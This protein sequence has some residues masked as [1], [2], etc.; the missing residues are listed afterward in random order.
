MALKESSLLV[1]RC[2][3]G[4][5]L[6]TRLQPSMLDPGPCSPTRTSL[7]YRAWPSLSSTKICLSQIS[8]HNSQL[9]TSKPPGL[10]P[11]VPSHLIM[12][13]CTSLWYRAWPSLSSTQM[14]QRRLPPCAESLHVNSGQM[15][16]CTLITVLHSKQ[17]SG[18][19]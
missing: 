18:Q 2:G 10:Q 9:V 19:H 7:W 8:R 4:C 1:S 16:S 11:K 3:S 13:I 14:C 12:T 17:L 15:A 6:P 5:P